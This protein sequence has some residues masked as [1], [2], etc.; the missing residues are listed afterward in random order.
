VLYVTISLF[1]SAVCTVHVCVC[2]DRKDLISI[3]AYKN[4]S[5]GDA[6]RFGEG[7][8]R[9]LSLSFSFGGWKETFL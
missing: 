4:I 6:S 5:D 3:A 8:R 9:E 7:I 1:L 2:I